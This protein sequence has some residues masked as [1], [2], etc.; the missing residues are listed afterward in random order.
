MLSINYNN[1]KLSYYL[2][3]TIFK[4]TSVFLP[5]SF[6]EFDSFQTFLLKNKKLNVSF[7]FDY[8]SNS[9]T[10]LQNIHFIASVSKSESLYLVPIK[11]FNLEEVVEKIPYQ[12]STEEEFLLTLAPLFFGKSNI[13]CLF[14]KDDILSEDSKSKLIS[15]LNSKIN[16][17]NAIIFYSTHSKQALHL[18]N[19]ISISK[20]T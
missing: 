12:L 14:V 4:K 11:Y 8:F 9:L 15:F 10:I 5:F 17:E 16:C 18:E 7:A 2:S 3:C 19:E 20:L 1:T 13:W 6:Y